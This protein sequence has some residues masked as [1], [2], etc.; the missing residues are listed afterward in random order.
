[1][2]TLLATAPEL[3]VYR[4]LTDLGYMPGVDF[5]FQSKMLGDYG[6][7]GSARADFEIPA[8]SMVIR[9]MGEYYHYG[10][11]SAEARDELQ[12]LALESSGI[13]VVDIDAEDA[14]RNAK[15]YVQEALKGIS[16]SRSSK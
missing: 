8:L 3:A 12:M 7:K 4:A 6:E 10:N 15:F 9:V 14:L 16:H 5:I 1:M 11:P 13:T 2:N